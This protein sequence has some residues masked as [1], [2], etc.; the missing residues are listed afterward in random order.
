MSCVRVY[1][2]RAALAMIFALRIGAQGM[3]PVHLP[4]QCRDEELQRAGMDCSEDNPCPVYLELNAVSRDGHKLFAAGNL[5][6]RSATLDSVL[7]TSLDEGVTWKEAA[8]RIPGA[9]L[10]L[11][12]FYDLQHG[13]ASGETQD[14]LPRDPFILVTGSGGDT[15]HRSPVS[16]AG[17]PGTIL[18]FRFDSASHGELV[19]DAGI[20]ASSG[21]YHSYESETGGDSWTIRGTATKLPD[22]REPAE[23]RDLRI[24]ASKDG[25]LWQI[26]QRDTQGSGDRW[27]AAASFLIE[28]ASCSGAQETK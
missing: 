27:T 22:S 13:W 17:S 26:E 4:F 3:D 18:S 16:E 7:L 11:I 1:T 15:W 12:Q 21:R 23:N 6:S 24:R 19:V 14:P 9:A 10:D 5:H 25:K 20:T 8:D 2:V 28:V